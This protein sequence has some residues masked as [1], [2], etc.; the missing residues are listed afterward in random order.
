MTLRK[1][2]VHSVTMHVDPIPTGT[3]D[4]AVC[5]VLRAALRAKT[6]S[7]AKPRRAALEAHE[8]AID[9]CEALGLDLDAAIN[10]ARKPVNIDRCGHCGTDLRS[11]KRKMYSRLIA[12]VITDINDNALFFACPD[13]GATFNPWDRN[14]HPELWAKANEH[15]YRYVP[16]TETG[17]DDEN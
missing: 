4:R 10:R 5:T 8:N 9:V 14:T 16:C 2:D 1:P 15:R 3:N 17:S 6:T 13:C 12:I 11:G 7:Q